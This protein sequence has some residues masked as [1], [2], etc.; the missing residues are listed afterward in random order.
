MIDGRGFITKFLDRFGCYIA[1]ALM[2]VF[3]LWTYLEPGFY[4]NYVAGD[5]FLI[6]TCYFLPWVI[7]VANL[8]WQ[9]NWFDKWLR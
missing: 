4:D 6:W 2:L 3:I 7:I 8:A 5:V 1:V 9:F